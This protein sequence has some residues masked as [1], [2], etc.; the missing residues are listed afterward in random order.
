MFADPGLIRQT[1]I[2]RA[3]S[4]P[5]DSFAEFWW[6]M[7]VK[8]K[9]PRCMR[10]VFAR[11]NSIPVFVELAPRRWRLSQESNCAE[12]YCVCDAVR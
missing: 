11:A 10:A 7:D 4:I 2:P 3:T 12:T 8:Q 9:R 5:F 1:E 6:G